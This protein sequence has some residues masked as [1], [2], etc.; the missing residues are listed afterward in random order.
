MTLGQRHDADGQ[1]NPAAHLRPRRPAPD[2]AR[3]GRAA[4]VRRSRRRYRTGSRR[5][6]PRID[7][8]RAAGR[9]QQRL[10]LAVDDLELDADLARARGRGTRRRSRPRRQASVAIRRARVTP[11]LRILS[12]Q[13]RSASIARS[14]AA[15]LRRPDA[16]MPSPSRMMREKASTTRKP[17]CGRRAPPAAGNYWCRDRARHRSDHR[18]P[19]P[20]RG[21][22]LRNRARE[23]GSADG[24]RRPSTRRGPDRR[25]SIDVCLRSAC[26]RSRA[27]SRPVAR[28]SSFIK[29]VLP[30]GP[31]ALA[32]LQGRVAA[33]LCPKIGQSVET[34]PGAARN[35]L[36]KQGMRACL[37][38][39]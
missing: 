6:H 37:F 23:I 17:S 29:L 1:R 24:Q 5:R 18:D 22:S 12:R 15:S 13:M 33:A 36:R 26:A 10:G 27:G 9:G 3:S 35:R 2:T 4:P 16:V 7:Q 34:A 8:R 19:S 38:L 11:R 21:M 39:W 32:P 30:L 28:T 14:I 31:T 20:A 25:A